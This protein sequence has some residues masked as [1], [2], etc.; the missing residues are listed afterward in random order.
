[1]TIRKECW[2]GCSNNLVESK[3]EEMLNGSQVKADLKE[4]RYYY[5]MKQVF[6]SAKEI[7]Q[8]KVLLSKVDRYNSVIKNAPAKLFIIYYSLYINF[9]IPWIH[10][11]KN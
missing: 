9:I 3:G 4:I 5:Q 1:M 8:P 6:D 10:D 7:I 11:N 2:K